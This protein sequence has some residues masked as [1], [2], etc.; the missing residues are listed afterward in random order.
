MLTIDQAALASGLSTTTIRRRIKDQSLP[1]E[2]IAGRWMIDPDVLGIS[3][4]VETAG[5]GDPGVHG[6]TPAAELVP[7]A[8]VM[9]Q[10]A[11]ELAQV[12]ERAARAETENLFLKERLAELRARSGAAAITERR[13]WWQRS[14]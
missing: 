3:T 8:S 2:M 12:S 11:N 7:Y 14:R 1:A 13:R 5:R 6:P 4:I 10:L 9:H